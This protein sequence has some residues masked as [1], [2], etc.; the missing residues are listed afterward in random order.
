MGEQGRIL[1]ETIFVNT[2]KGLAQ[3]GYERNTDPIR[4]Y[5]DWSTFTQ[6]RDSI[7]QR[8]ITNRLYCSL[9][10]EGSATCPCIPHQSGVREN[11][12]LEQQSQRY[13]SRLSK[14]TLDG[15]TLWY[16]ET[17]KGFPIVLLHPWPADHAM[18]MFQVP[19]L[20]EYYRVITPDHRGLGNSDKP[21]A[22]YTL[23]GLSNDVNGLMNRLDIEKAFIVG[24]SL[25]GAVAQRFCLDHP[26]KVQA[27]IW[28][29][30]PKL[31][32]DEFLFEVGGRKRP[33]PEVY[34]EALESK[35]Y[36]HFR[37]TVWK[38]NMRHMFHKDF[39]GS[40]LASY[41]IRYLFE[42]RY[43]RLNRD[44]RGAIGLINALRKEKILHELKDVKMPVAIL[45]GD[46]DPTLPYCE[47]QQRCCPQA[48]Y[49][50][51]ENS[52][53]MCVM[54]QAEEFNKITLEFLK[55]HSPTH[56]P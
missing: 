24:L 26:E 25:G 53:H 36:I 10:R 48:E 51:V 39:V 54:D 12:C 33:L 17:G 41:L 11:F 31:P 46:N 27:S 3:N 5:V 20:S 40:P 4:K 37:R 34:L 38:A 42:E 18:W 29:G 16:E 22:G 1:D 35:G 44:P 43:A 45:V 13:C 6:Q 30:A 21:A 28:V 50:V 19:V 23:K 56:P 15:L 32:T 55:T 9:V 52:G 8:S 2:K 14:I 49:H 7:A 47:E